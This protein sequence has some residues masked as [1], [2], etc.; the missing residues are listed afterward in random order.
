MPS[1]SLYLLTLSLCTGSFPIHRLPY[2]FLALSFVIEIP[3]LNANGVEPDQTS[4]LTT[5]DLGLQYL[6]VP[7]LWDA[8]HE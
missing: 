2:L 1:L 6:P 5:S 4:Q 3:L 7:L 8:I